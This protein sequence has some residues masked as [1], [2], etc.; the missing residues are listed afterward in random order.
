VIAA[1]LFSCV[2]HCTKHESTAATIAACQFPLIGTLGRGSQL[3]AGGRHV[4]VL[5]LIP[6]IGLLS[7]DAFG[8]ICAGNVSGRWLQATNG[9]SSAE[10]STGMSRNML[11]V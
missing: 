4:W 10:A 2:R 11:A 3:A 5:L 8:L 1:A 9:K 6:F 7:A